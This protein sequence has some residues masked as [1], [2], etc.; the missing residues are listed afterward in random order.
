MK[1]RCK[2]CGQVF[3]ESAIKLIGRSAEDYLGMP[4][5]EEVEVSPCC[6]ADFE[7]VKETEEYEDI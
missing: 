3:D 2:N 1:M 6:D 4:C 5:F 7:L